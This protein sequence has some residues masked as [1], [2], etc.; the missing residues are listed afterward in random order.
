MQLNGWYSTSHNLG[1]P[2]GQK[3]Q[4]FPA[5][6]DGLLL[7]ISWLLVKLLRD[8]VLAFNAFFLLTFPLTAVGAYI[9]S[10]LIGI[11]RVFAIGVA[12]LYTFLPY[13]WMH[14]AAHLFLSMY[15]L[16]PISIGWIIRELRIDSQPARLEMRSRQVFSLVLPFVLGGAVGSAGLYY[17]A[18]TLVL[19]SA[20]ILM[21]ATTSGLR[22]IRRM[23][24]VIT[25]ILVALSVQF[26]QILM[27]QAEHGP[28]LDFVR[29]QAFDVERYS[30][31]LLDLIRPIPQHRLSWMANF[32]NKSASSIVPGE[33]T[34]FLG[35]FGAMGLLILIGVLI[36]PRHVKVS[37]SV[38]SPLSRLFLVLLLF[39]SVGGFNQL[40]ASVGITQVRVWQRSSVFLGFCA[41]AAFF[42][43]LEHFLTQSS[44]LAVLVVTCVAIL[45]VLDTNRVMPPKEF[46]R[47]A[48]EWRNDGE[49][50]ESIATQ[51][52][53]GARVLQLPVIN[54]PEN[55]PV[56]GLQDY[57][58]LRG[59]L[60][61]KTLC[62]SY[63]VVR[64]RDFER[65]ARWQNLDLDRL[66]D[67][68]QSQGFD[69]VWFEKRA[70]SDDFA[71]VSHKIEAR[72]GPPVVTDRLDQVLIF[73]LRINPNVKRL[74][75]HGD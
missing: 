63:G 55:G 19:L 30:L 57:A 56:G 25:G 47:I 24:V 34:A 45:G 71:E 31:R 26:A 66:L 37:E 3:L 44:G 32:S 16:V 5:I 1:Y 17:A 8:P 40:L 73:D 58:Q 23:F 75:C 43:V 9:G 54:F 7:A 36:W 62:W 52:G 35:I 4:D 6:A 74:E 48:N 39:A 29:R 46:D 50:V 13:H 42:V 33:S 28:N 65:S 2:F 21:N 22:S 68:A 18:F 10:R 53:S 67:E 12:V 60:F 27:W 20:A 49:L 51:F 11:T 15:P 69:A 59:Q 64:G 72:L 38:L 41:L 61:S 70:Y 14:G